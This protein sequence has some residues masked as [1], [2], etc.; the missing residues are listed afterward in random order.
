MR[1]DNKNTDEKIRMGTKIRTLIWC[2][3]SSYSSLAYIVFLMYLYVF[4]DNLH[5]R[6]FPIR[7]FGRVAREIS[8]QHH[9]VRRSGR[10]TQEIQKTSTQ[11]LTGAAQQNAN[12]SNEFSNRKFQCTHGFSKVFVFQILLVANCTIGGTIERNRA[13]SN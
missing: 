11:L 10:R 1:I 9:T 6:S 8:I 7:Q 5:D 2:V 12:C 4:V 13:R 3:L